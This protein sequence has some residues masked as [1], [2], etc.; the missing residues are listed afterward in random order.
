MTRNWHVARRRAA[1]HG[2]HPD[3][4]VDAAEPVGAPDPTGRDIASAATNAAPAEQASGARARDAL[5]QAAGQASS[6]DIRTV[7]NEKSDW[8]T[9]TQVVDQLMVWTPPRL[10]AGD[11]TGR[12]EGFS[13]MSE[14]SRGR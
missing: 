2:V 10:H 3:A 6:S 12:A 11:C 8:S 9:G 14:P 1:D 7:I 4:T 13:R 5:V